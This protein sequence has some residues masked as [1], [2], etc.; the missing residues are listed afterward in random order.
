MSAWFYRLCCH[1]GRPVVRTTI[2]C[3]VLGEENLPPRGGALLA[4]NHESFYDAMIVSGLL[5]RPIRWLSGWQAVEPV[6]KPMLRWLDVIPVVAGSAGVRAAKSSIHHL[7][8]GGLVGIFPEGKIRPLASSVV[9][10][11]SVEASIFKLARL[12]RVPVIP[13]VV[14]GSEV[15]GH[16]RSWLPGS[17][18]RCVV[19]LGEPMDAGR[20]D[21]AVAYARAM[22]ALYQRACAERDR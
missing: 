11:G 1:I 4:V 19:A 3:R 17:G 6:W 18:G 12:A 15:F 16:W 8:T 5:A 20:G 22:C 13:C 14:L 10:G 21:L 9:G 2:C 7:R